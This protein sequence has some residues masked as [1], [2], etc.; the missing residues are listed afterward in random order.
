MEPCATPCVGPVRCS[1]SWEGV[2]GWVGDTR[3]PSIHFRISGSEPSAA[4]AKPRPF[5]GLPEPTPPCRAPLRGR[6]TV[7]RAFAENLREGGVIPNTARP[8][9]PP[10]QQPPPRL[11]QCWGRGW[12]KWR[13]IRRERDQ[14]P[15]PFPPSIGG[16][17]SRLRRSR[18]AQGSGRPKPPVPTQPLPPLRD[19]VSEQRI[20]N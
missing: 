18:G 12:Q 16:T 9:N 13:E 10:P 5:G 17:R 20:G 1:P 6:G 7:S 11:P 19:F 14:Q 8:T 15:N 3:E 2:G 4:S